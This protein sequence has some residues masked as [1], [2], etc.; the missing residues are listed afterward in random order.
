MR[1]PLVSVIT[2]T[3]NHGGYIGRCIESLIAQTYTNWEMAVVDDGSTDNTAEIV[4]SYD[5]PRITY[6][7][8]EN[9]GVQQLGGT[10]NSGLRRT[11]GELVTML[12][13]DDTWPAYRLE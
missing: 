12:A 13:S 5:D 8:Q 2:P 1:T 7:Y 3:F 6:L 9:R 11:K 4:K 10:I